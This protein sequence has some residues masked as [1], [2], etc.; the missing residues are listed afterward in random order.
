MNRKAVFGFLVLAFI[1]ASLTALTLLGR[2]Q[3]A[4][5]LEYSQIEEIAAQNCRF[6]DLGFEQPGLSE[7]THS[8]MQR[9]GY[10]PRP[11]LYAHVGNSYVEGTS[12]C[13]LVAFSK[14]GDLNWTVLYE[15]KDGSVREL[16]AKV[17]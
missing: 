15:A 14:S 12:S 2:E 4:P 13:W 5:V 9:A 10:D 17:H 16:F 7:Y 8:L 1:A 6:T 11:W 3:L